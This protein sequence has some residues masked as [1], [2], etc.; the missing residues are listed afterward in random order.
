MSGNDEGK[1]I[2]DCSKPSSNFSFNVRAMLLDQLVGVI[3]P[4]TILDWIQTK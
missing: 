4:Y 3:S 1:K 2:Q